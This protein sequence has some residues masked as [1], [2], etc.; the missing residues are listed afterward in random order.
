MGRSLNTSDAGIDDSLLEICGIFG[1]HV[2]G[3]RKSER[4]EDERPTVR[5][6]Q[7]VERANIHSPVASLCFV[8]FIWQELIDLR[9]A[10]GHVFLYLERFLRLG[11]GPA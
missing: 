9:H 5:R 8:Q 7:L 10:E 6:S 3:G 4:R 11:I 2:S 1:R